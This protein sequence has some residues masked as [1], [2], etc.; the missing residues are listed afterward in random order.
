MSEVISK[1]QAH[2]LLPSMSIRRAFWARSFVMRN[3]CP[4][5]L[6]MTKCWCSTMWGRSPS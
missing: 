3:L 5:M 6:R 1:D 4:P 2:H